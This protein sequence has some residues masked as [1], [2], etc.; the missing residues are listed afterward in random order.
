MK[1]SIYEISESCQIPR[2]EMYYEDI[3]FCFLDKDLRLIF[4][5][6][7]NFMMTKINLQNIIIEDYNLRLQ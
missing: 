7:P 1:K 3:F 5:F 2:L 6:I 4:G